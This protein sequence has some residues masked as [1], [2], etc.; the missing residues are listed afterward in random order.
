MQWSKIRHLLLKLIIAAGMSG[1]DRRI[2]LQSHG[3]F[4]SAVVFLTRYRLWY[5]VSFVVCLSVSPSVCDGCV[6]AKR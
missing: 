6:V 5:D 1:L 4:L 3:N 2:E